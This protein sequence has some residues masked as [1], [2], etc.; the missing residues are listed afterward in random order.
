MISFFYLSLF[1]KQR[2][3]T[4]WSMSSKRKLQKVLKTRA[5]WK[6]PCDLKKTTKKH[7][8]EDFQVLNTLFD[9]EPHSRRNDGDFSGQ[10]R[11]LKVL[12]LCLFLNIHCSVWYLISADF[13]LEI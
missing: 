8:L 4:V 10:F 12:S 1:V 13:R 2:C 6:L 3:W 9:D 11:V 7:Y 5:V